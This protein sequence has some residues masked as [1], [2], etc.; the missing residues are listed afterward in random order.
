[1]GDRLADRRARSTW[2]ALACVASMSVSIDADEGPE[3]ASE[4]HR[5]FDT[6]AADITEVAMTIQ[7]SAVGAERG[8]AALRQKR[9]TVEL[10]FGLLLLAALLVLLW[11]RD[12]ISSEA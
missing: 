7:S 8:I 4:I 11:L 6:V 1:M 3:G 5:Y 12:R 9:N 10:G 2:L